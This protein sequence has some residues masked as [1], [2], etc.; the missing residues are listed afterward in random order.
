MDDSPLPFWPEAA[1]AA[2]RMRSGPESHLMEL[3]LSKGTKEGGVQSGKT[4]R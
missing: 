2:G 4:S 1:H 3:P